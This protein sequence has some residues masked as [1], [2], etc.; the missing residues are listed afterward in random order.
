[1]VKLNNGLNC[2]VV[3][4]KGHLIIDIIKWWNDKVSSSKDWEIFK[5]LDQDNN[6]R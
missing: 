4:F 2:H 3:A 5:S 1:M 6:N